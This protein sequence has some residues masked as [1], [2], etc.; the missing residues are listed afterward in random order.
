MVM[1]EQNNNKDMTEEKNLVMAPEEE[2]LQNPAIESSEVQ[3]NREGAPQMQGNS[4]ETEII[5]P[6]EMNKKQEEILNEILSEVLEEYTKTFK[7]LLNSIKTLQEAYWLLYKLNERPLKLKTRDYIRQLQRKKD[8]IYTEKSAE[9]TEKI[10]RAIQEGNE[11]ERKK[12]VEEKEQLD[13]LAS[14][15]TILYKKLEDRLNSYKRELSE[16]TRRK[17]E[18][19][20]KLREL[21]LGSTYLTRD[22]V[23]AVKKILQ[24]WKQIGHVLPRE[25]KDI[26]EA[27]QTYVQA[28]NEMQKRFQEAQKEGQERNYET[29]KE[30]LEELKQIQ[31][32]SQGLKRWKDWLPFR[33]KFLNIKDLWDQTG[34]VPRSKEHIEKE[35][36]KLK[37]ELLKFEKKLLEIKREAMQ[38]NLKKMLDIIEELKKINETEIESPK[39]FRELR[40]RVR[41]LERSAQR[42]FLLPRGRQDEVRD[43]ITFLVGEFYKKT[44]EFSEELAAE[45]EKRASQKAELLQQLKDTI[46]SEELSMREKNDKIYRLKR[47]W[48]DKTG[49]NDFAQAFEM[50]NEFKALTQEF[51]KMYAEYK[52]NLAAEYPKNLEK[53][54]QLVEKLEEAYKHI[55]DNEELKKVLDETIEEWKQ[56]G[57]VPQEE[58]A[59]LHDRLFRIIKYIYYNRLLADKTIRRKNKAINDEANLEMFK[60]RLD[61]MTASANPLERLRR[62]QRKLANRRSEIIADIRK[63]EKTFSMFTIQDESGIFSGQLERKKEA[64]T[65]R[66]AVIEEELRLL[67]K[68]IAEIKAAS[69]PQNES[70][71]EIPEEE[72]SPSE[73]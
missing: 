9:L 14:N 6:E 44:D 36:R 2:N 32:E 3:S 30:L 26:R 34:P 22:A 55:E 72:N 48:W 25:Y 53:K 43:A 45:R 8:E 13:R 54:N 66:K 59:K 40:K 57:E 47:Q 38:N 70:A 67:K 61:I 27:Y 46:A 52:K 73:E 50:Y 39:Q 15:F 35:Y 12:W 69:A 37:G 16:N 65:K 58:K 42:I 68:K 19:L 11:A 62:E 10:A 51:Q 60:I 17:K 41:E 21:V 71:E 28:F 49:P 31:E 1:T 5:P 20:A 7:E 29:K 56:I 63:I 33:A 4:Q 64:L 23:I 18:L 24:E